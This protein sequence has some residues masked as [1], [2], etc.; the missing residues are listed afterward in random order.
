MDLE[1]GKSCLENLRKITT[2][3][4]NSINQNGY[5]LV[6]YLDVKAAYNN[7]KHNIL[8]KILEELDCSVNITKYIDKWMKNR[9]TEYII[10]RKQTETRIT[11]RELPQ[12]AVLSPILYTLYTHNIQKDLADDIKITKFA[13]DIA[14]YVSSPNRETNKTKIKEPI[15]IINNN[16]EELGLEL[17][18]RKTTLVEYNKYGIQ[19]KRLNIKVK[20]VI[21]GNEKEAKFL[22]IW[23]D[24]GLKYHR[25]IEV[26]RAK[27]N[28]ANSIITYLARKTKGMETNTALMLYKSLVRSV[29]DCASFIYYP[30][31]K[32]MSI[33]LERAQFQGV[34]TA[35][36]YR[37]STPTNVMI[38][39]AE[40]HLLKHRANFLA[41]NFL[42][43]VSTYGDPK[44]VK[45]S[46]E[47]ERGEAYNG[48]RNPLYNKSIIIMAWQ[49]I[50]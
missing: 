47:L 50:K 35:L 5:T 39:E 25:Q 6:A 3:T 7:V 32:N 34:R 16:L 24:N 11:H 21:I 9:E 13:D 44:F 29:T 8:I 14:I 46:E 20:D 22:G 23:L 42:A 15:N 10:S 28:K 33:K 30:N 43:K 49:R 4:K 27:V 37:N 40:I 2:D 26:V 12:G 45:A 18:I 41:R 36:G 31:V 38:A 19:D 1:E 17:S 48:F